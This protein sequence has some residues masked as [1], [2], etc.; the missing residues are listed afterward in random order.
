M[1]PSVINDSPDDTP[2]STAGSP[3]A[4]PVPPDH[5]SLL[6]ILTSSADFT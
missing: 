2:P 1:A 4:L 5:D 3:P 6:E